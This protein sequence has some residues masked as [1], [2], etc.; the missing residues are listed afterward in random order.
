MN[1]RRYI[2]ASLAVF[3]F[4][5]SFEW[6]FHGG[7][8]R[9]WYIRTAPLWRSEAEMAIYLPF[10][11]AGQMLFAFVF[12]YI[13]IK[14]YENKGLMEGVRFGLWIGLL[15]L[16]GMLISYAVSPYPADMVCAWVMGAFIE[17]VI[18]G[19][20]AALLYKSKG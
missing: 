5:S 9:D 13:F 19:G 16:S 14:G 3:V 12:S 1:I 15:T 4:M 11:L 6:V 7:V 17:L 18:A 8:M 10:L 2:F 20:I